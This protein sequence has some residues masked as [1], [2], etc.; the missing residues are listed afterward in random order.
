MS[1]FDKL[2]SKFAS[3]GESA[4]TIWQFIKFNIVGILCTAIQL[5]LVNVLPGVFKDLNVPLPG[6]L[7][8]IF[9][10][11][12]VGK[13]NATLSYILPYFI[14]QSV[15]CT[16]GYFLNM[17][18]TFKA[19]APKFYFVIYF[20]VTAIMILVCTWVQGV[21]ANIFARSDIGLIRSLHRTLASLC[22]SITMTAVIYPLQKYVLF[23]EK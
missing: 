18:T 19:D 20:V 15:S 23:K 17:K 13:G 12:I 8:K 4:N 6:I 1:I 11:D 3:K 21:T 16:V 22:G 9:T 7:S 2:D 14:S 5:I 10:E